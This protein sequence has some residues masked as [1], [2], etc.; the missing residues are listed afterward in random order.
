[1]CSGNTVIF[2]MFRVPPPRCATWTACGKFWN[3]SS[4][5]TFLD[6][7]I[8]RLQSNKNLLTI[9]LTYL[10]STERLLSLIDKDPKI[11]NNKDVIKVSQLKTK[12]ELVSISLAKAMNKAYENK[13]IAKNKTI[14]DLIESEI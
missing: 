4:S 1:M 8:E 6:K 12:K 7:K 13:K 3:I 5:I 9:E 14:N 10:T 2:R 11:L